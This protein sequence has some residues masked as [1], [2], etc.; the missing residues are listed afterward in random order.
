[1]NIGA[2]ITGIGSFAPEKTLT[3][4]DLEKIVDTSDEWIQQRTGI[5][6]RRITTTEEST[7][8][9]AYNASMSAI[10]MAGIEPKD[11]DAIIVGTATPDYP[12]PS[13]ACVLQDK[14]KNKKA[15]AFDLNAGCTGFIYALSIADSFIKT[16]KCET[17][18]VVGA[19]IISKILNWKDRTSCVLFGDGAGAVILQKDNFDSIKSI[20]LRSDGAYVDLLYM[21]AGGSKFPASPETVAKKMHTVHLKGK[22]VFKIAVNSLSSL[23]EELLEK[24]GT[25]IDTIDLFI[26]HQANKRIIDAVSQKLSVPDEKVFINI[27]KYGNTSSASI[28]IAFDE[29]YKEGLIKKGSKILMTAFGAGLTWGGAVV[30][31]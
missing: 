8:Y 30:E 2:K 5:R 14:L 29:A 20:G 7:S 22:E 13:T 21:P 12:F 6:E 15:L 26:P 24:S 27:Q 28:P 25:S 18:L 23:A 10:K 16:G 3:N 19:E 11:I 4:E 9:L 31:L 1:M 17:V